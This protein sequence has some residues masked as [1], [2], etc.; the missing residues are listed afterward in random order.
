MF[1]FDNAPSHRKF[2]DGTLNAK[3]MNV[4]PG[5][6]QPAMKDTTWNGSIQTMTLPNETPKGMQMVLEER[7]IDT[8]GWRAERMQ[9]EIRTFNDFQNA[10]TI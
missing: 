7:G 1:I 10:K 5:G 3:V 4:R 9:Q 2:P 6:K 8:S